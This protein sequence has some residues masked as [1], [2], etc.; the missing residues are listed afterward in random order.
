MQSS[1]NETVRAKN[2]VD[3]ILRFVRF[4]VVFHISIILFVENIQFV[5]IRVKRRR[6]FLHYFLL[7]S[8]VYT[9]GFRFLFC[10]FWL[11]LFAFSL[12]NLTLTEINSGMINVQ[13]R[14][15]NIRS[16]WDSVRYRVKIIQY[17]SM[18]FLF[19]HTILGEIY[20]HLLSLKVVQTGKSLEL[21]TEI[22]SLSKASMQKKIIKN[23]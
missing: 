2:P 16:I 4:F 21:D 12:A 18:E 13:V 23:C 22:F 11:S 3:D 9:F 1:D 5:R 17:I 8:G 19:A 6:K 10:C 20:Q 14:L 7:W 15:F